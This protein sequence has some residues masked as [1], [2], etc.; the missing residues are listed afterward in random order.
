MS[1]YVQTDRP[2]KITTAL[3]ADAVLLTGL[4]G[5][6]ACRSSSSSSW[7]CSRPAR[8]AG[9][10]RGGPRPAGGWST[11]TCPA[12]RTGTSTASS[13]ASA[14][15]RRDQ[16]F[17]AYRAE[18]VPQFWLLTKRVQSRIFQHLTVPDILKKVLD[19][20]DVD[21][22]APGHVPPAR[23]LRPVPRDRLRLRQ[24]A[25]GRG[26]HLLLLQARRRRPQ[27]GRGQHAAEPP[28]PAR[29]ERR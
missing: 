12:R 4:S 17:T 28:R 18:V 1:T 19:G 23:L 22:R 7:N 3:G 14:R 24:P 2:I 25:D 5:Q 16:T 29:A 9:R 21:L 8:Q 10:L 15:A 6:E 27:D 13:A 20:L 26:G 11:S